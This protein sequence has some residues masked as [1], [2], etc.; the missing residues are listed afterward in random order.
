MTVHYLERKLHMA[1]TVL[2]LVL[3]GCAKEGTKFY[4]DGQEAGLAI[5]S[6]KGNNLM[7]CYI[8]GV[9]WQTVPRFYPA[10]ISGGSRYELFIQ[11]SNATGLMDT[12]RFEWDGN[13]AANRNNQGTVSLSLL[14]PKGFSYKEFNALQGKRIAVDGNNGY[15][16]SDIRALNPLQ[17]Q[18]T[19]SV[20]FHTASLDSIA[21]QW[22]SGKISGLIEAGFNGTPLTKGRFDH[23]IEPGQ[24]FF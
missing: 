16:Y 9:P 20:Y 17:V 22:Y 11:K 8:N 15:F 1:V 14:L 5:F 23:T 3:T 4:T 7:T 18:G 10:I 13:V 12:V 24:V 2:A 6:D 21:P 19:G